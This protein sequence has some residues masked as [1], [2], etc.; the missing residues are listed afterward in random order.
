MRRGRRQWQVIDENTPPM[1][2]VRTPYDT[3]LAIFFGLVNG[4][5]QVRYPND[6]PGVFDL[7]HPTDVLAEVQ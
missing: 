4:R 2:E 6:R 5:A 7:L 1:T 3:E